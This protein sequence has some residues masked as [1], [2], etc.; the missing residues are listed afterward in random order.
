MKKKFKMG[1]ERFTSSESEED[2]QHR[3]PAG[4]GHMLLKQKQCTGFWEAPLIVI[5][6]SFLD[7]DSEVQL[8]VTLGVLEELALAGIFY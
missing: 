8:I 1:L 3:E 6:C 5:L 7:T 4:S 2:F